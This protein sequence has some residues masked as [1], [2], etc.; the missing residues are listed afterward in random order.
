MGRE[1]LI[2]V[3]VH[4]RGLFSSGLAVDCVVGF[5]RCRS[6]SN[7]SQGF[8]YGSHSVHGNIS[9]LARSVQSASA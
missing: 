9:A 7:L 3:S 8:R 2:D 1:W 5:L 6:L 4:R